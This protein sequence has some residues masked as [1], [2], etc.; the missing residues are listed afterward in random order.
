M[1]QSYQ[2]QFK[3]ILLLVLMVFANS[4]A[5]ANDD[6]SNPWS[7]ISEREFA[8]KEMQRPI[9]PKKYRTF[10][11]D[12]QAL[13]NQ[14]ADAPLRFSAV[15]EE[16][17]VILLLPL[18]NGEMER[19]EIYD[20]PIMEAELAAQF[21][22][23]HSYAGVGIDDPT[24]SLRFDVTQLGFHALVLSA[25]HGSIYID[26]YSK[27]D[28][29]HYITYFKKDFEKI[30]NAFECHLQTELSGIGGQDFV[31]DV[32]VN[33][34]SQGDCQLRTYR[35]AL[36]CTGEYAAFHNGTTNSVMAAMNTTMTRVNGIFERDL[37]V[38]MIL[39]NGNENLIFLDANTDPY[40]DN[41]TGQLINESHVQCNTIIG[42]PNYDIGHVFSTGGGGLAGLG[43]VCN[44]GNKG[45]GVTGTNNP[46]G[47]PFDVDYVAHEIGHQFG[48]N[49][50]FNN[51]C[52][53]NRNGTTS[54]EPGSGSS[55]MGY[56]GICGPNVQF[57]SDDYFHAMSIQEITNHITGNGNSCANKT[58][59]GNNPPTVV[60]GADYVLPIS[61]PF[62]LT[63]TGNDVDGDAITYCWEQM[64][65][66]I[67]NMPPVATNTEGPSF[68]SLDPTVESHR[69][70]PKLEDIVNGVN[71]D[72]EELPSV[73]RNMNFRVTVRDNHQGSGCTEEDDVQLTFSND[74]GPF[75]VQSPN[76]METWMV[77]AAQQVTYQ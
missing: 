31:D 50:T 61:T 67:A 21:P 35:L 33:S 9:V 19:F 1:T 8:Y 62:K 41:D 14:L 58:N 26:P 5:F 51:S 7:E 3:T 60:A 42:N 36:S 74:A 39:V 70:F 46:I 37:N 66:E 52:G 13:Q 45:R 57:N 40:D 75:L 32:D 23:I 53:G 55:I 63:A 17:S 38:N 59:T 65:N 49:H 76:M 29:E 54:V 15:A 71:S 28:T 16:Q 48:A 56:A 20:A 27:E 24:A 2:S 68:R 4:F 69:Y 72:W 64:D 34:L 22:M 77:G 12:M 30:G 11:L 25:K 73:S 10:K 47:D 43:V 6:N 18:P 44:S